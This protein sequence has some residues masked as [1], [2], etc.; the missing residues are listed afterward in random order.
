MKRLIT[1]ALILGIMPFTFAQRPFREIDAEQLV[2]EILALQDLDLNYEDLYENLLQ[3]LSN[4]LDLNKASANEFRALFILS[5]LQ[6][7][8]LL[9]YRQDYGPFLSVYELQSI[10]GFD[11]ESIYRLL[12]FVQVAVKDTDRKKIA[13]RILN[14][15]NRYWIN[16][17]ERTLQ[18]RRGYTTDASE[19]GAYA[20]SPNKIYSRFRAFEANDYSIGFTLEKDAGEAMKWNPSTKYYG[21]DFVSGHLSL[22][23]IS[24]VKTLTLG[25]YQMQFGQGLVFGGGFGIGKGAETILAL[26]R[27][28][29]G[30]IPY[31]SVNESG[32]FRGAAAQV[33]LAKHTD[34]ILMHSIF[35]Q[36]MSSQS[37]SIASSILTSGF[38]R[39]RNEI[40]NRKRLP[41][42]NVGI[43][44]NHQRNNLDAGLTLLH[45]KFDLP[46]I[47]TP[48]RYNYFAFN[49]SENLVGSVFL[50]YNITGF[51]F[52]SEVAQSSSGGTGTILGVLSSIG[53]KTETALSYRSYDPDFH[54]FYA[55][56]LS[57]NAI[58]QN[59]R[60]LYWGFKQNVNNKLFYAGYIDLFRFQWMRS[61]A[62]APSEGHEYL[63]RISYRPTNESQVFVMFREEA[64]ARNT[65][66]SANVYWLDQG[67]K[68]NLILNADYNMNKKLSLRTRLQFSTFSLAGN[69]TGGMTLVQD[70]NYKHRKFNFS[71]RQALFDTDDFENRQYVYERDVLY[72][73]S[74]PAYNGVGIR[75]YAMIQFKISKSFDCWIRYA[76]TMYTDRDF[77]GNG[78]ERI[79]GNLRSD[80]KLQTRFRF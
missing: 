65:N 63:F 27:P 60:A 49:G 61:R 70:L 52:F 44:L 15:Q 46:I 56:A 16:R 69:E 2:E 38:H 6:I 20:G 71:F 10:S 76:R 79:S 18:I 13:G 62:F 14:S 45:T 12:P 75:N 42:R 67:I 24:R 31:T 26:R 50:N 58:A 28:N 1:I 11:T 40:N 21:F 51:S 54:S 59:E 35:N 73:F 7:N 29:R 3:I 4:P 5:E 8:A 74:L 33:K 64:K 23:N 57:E 39:T 53:N 47:R 55:Q 43:I 77:I 36:D 9:N 72:A 37:D 41:E 30:I 25:D 48:R 78:S 17:Y 32:F 22:H 80:I 19:A 66:E 34:L 68:R